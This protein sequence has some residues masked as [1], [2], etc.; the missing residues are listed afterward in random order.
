MLVEFELEGEGG[1]RTL[2]SRTNAEESQRNRDLKAQ[3]QAASRIMAR[4]GEGTEL[5]CFAAAWMAAKGRGPLANISCATCA[6]MTMMCCCVQLDPP[7]VESRRVTFDCSML[8]PLALF[9]FKDVAG[10]LVERAAV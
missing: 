4:W 3:N 1:E 9:G 10:W 6:G 7:C 8:W 2:K 5:R